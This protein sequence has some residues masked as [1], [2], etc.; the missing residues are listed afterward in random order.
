M[1]SKLFF[2]GEGEASVL[3]IG[4]IWVFRKEEMLTE[5]RTRESGRVK[6][7]DGGDPQRRENPLKMHASGVRRSLFA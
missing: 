4:F 3:F 1:C 7:Q 6:K 2:G 5:S